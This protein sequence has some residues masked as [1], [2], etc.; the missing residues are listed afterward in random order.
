MNFNSDLHNTIETI[1]LIRTEISV[2]KIFTRSI[3]LNEGLYSYYSIVKIKFLII[4]L[5]AAMKA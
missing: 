3:E 4:T 2:N 1:I 5:A